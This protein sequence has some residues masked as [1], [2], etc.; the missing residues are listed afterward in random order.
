MKKMIMVAVCLIATLTFAAQCAATTKR[1]TQCKRNASPD[2]QYCW[3]HGGT[4]KA[5]RMASGESTMTRVSQCA[6]TTKKGT[7]CKRKA[8]AGSKFC[9]QHDK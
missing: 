9:W 4:T 5:E 6:A 1:G 7:Q 3:Q 2:S 8:K